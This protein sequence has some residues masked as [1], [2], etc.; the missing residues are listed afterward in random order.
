LVDELVVNVGVSSDATLELVQSIGD[1]K[2]VI[3]ESRWDERHLQGGRV[4][5]EQTDLS[6]RRCT[7]DLCLYLQADEV[8][9][10]DEAASLRAALARLLAEPRAEGL[11]FDYVHFYGSYH[12][13]AT[14][15]RFYRREVRA[16]RNG[17]GVRSWRDAQGFRVFPSGGDP[18]RARKLRVIPAGVRVLHYGWCRPPAMQG[19]K[20]AE[21]GRWYHGDVL[22]PSSDSP[23]FRYDEGARVAPFTGTHPSYIQHWVDAADW[24]YTPRSRKVRA[25]TLRVDLLDLFEAATRIRVGEYRNYKLLR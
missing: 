1:P 13:V 19:T 15:R 21:L 10:E 16:F 20:Q 11:L 2:M 22:G 3:F 7:G 18:R 12:T 4:L 24:S 14:G 5:A 17:L 6:L 9:H 23:T 25:R 8:L